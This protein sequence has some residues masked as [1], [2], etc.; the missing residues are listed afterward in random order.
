MKRFLTV[1]AISSLF[2]A[3]SQT[4][5]GAPV[6]KIATTP[7]AESPP[8][9]QAT[10]NTSTVVAVGD[11]FKTPLPQGVVLQQPYTPT[12]DI[13]VANPSGSVGRRIEF[14]Y[15]DGDPSK[16]L[17]KFAESMSKAGFISP[18][19]PTEEQGVARQTFQKSGY[20]AVFARAQGEDE[21]HRRN[22][23]AHGFVV[24]AWPQGDGTDQVPSN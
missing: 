24:V 13:A 20:G 4:P 14:E 18:N 7:V 21:A 10:E 23:L 1:A 3:C 5:D 22:P 8:T 17:A 16:A 12:M 19:G 11:V 15:Q 9:A 6:T 2:A